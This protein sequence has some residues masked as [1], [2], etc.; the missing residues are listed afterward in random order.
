MNIM[1]LH[2][3]EKKKSPGKFNPVLD[4]SACHICHHQ[5]NPKKPS[6]CLMFWSGGCSALLRPLNDWWNRKIC[7]QAENIRG[8]FHIVL[9]SKAKAQLDHATG[10]WYK[11]TVNCCDKSS[12]C[13]KRLWWGWITTNPERRAVQKGWTTATAI[14]LKWSRTNLRKYSLFTSQ[15]A[16]QACE[17][18]M[19]AFYNKRYTRGSLH[20]RQTTYQHKECLITL[21]SN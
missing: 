8:E 21:C 6:W 20:I 16:C 13:L 4:T 10:R 11:W 9:W 18:V 14:V 1:I 5:K 15:P 12:S 7:S 19:L 2:W 3:T 17:Q